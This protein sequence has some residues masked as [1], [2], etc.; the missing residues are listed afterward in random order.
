ML[1]CLRCSR[2][3]LWCGGGGSRSRGLRVGLCLSTSVRFWERGEEE[4]GGSIL[5]ELGL[6]VLEVGEKLTHY[7]AVVVC[8]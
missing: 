8:P 3:G 4:R 1:L 6:V 7:E 2:L 5:A